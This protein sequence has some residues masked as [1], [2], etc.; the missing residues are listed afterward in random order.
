LKSLNGFGLQDI[1][2]LD[3]G[4]QAAAEAARAKV[5]LLAGRPP[6]TRDPRAVVAGLVLATLE[7]PELEPQLIARARAA[8][9]AVGTRERHADAYAKAG[10]A[11]PTS[12]PGI[13]D[14]SDKAVTE[15]LL[16]EEILARRTPR[17]GSPS[18]R[19]M[20]LRRTG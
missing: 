5:N 16:L 4:P 8:I 9:P 7:R 12:V 13:L 3:H 20:T 1:S 6:G 11:A 10:Q 2:G 15:A 19:P 18:R 17:R 14:T